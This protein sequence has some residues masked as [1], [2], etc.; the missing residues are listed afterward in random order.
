[1]GVPQ[2]SQK[3]KYATKDRCMSTT[4][5]F[6]FYLLCKEI[7]HKSMGNNDISVNME[8]LKRFMLISSSFVS[9]HHHASFHLAS[10]YANYEWT[11]NILKNGMFPTKNKRAPSYFLWNWK[12]F[13]VF[14]IQA[15][16]FNHTR[17]HTH[18][19]L[20]RTQRHGACAHRGL[21]SFVLLQGFDFQSVW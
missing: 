14:F 8:L 10:T 20:H 18:K 13:C 16:I 9:G 2:N 5:T 6:N 11:N 3:G 15:D 12:P 7:L 1:M 4:K 19:H 17:T 21:S